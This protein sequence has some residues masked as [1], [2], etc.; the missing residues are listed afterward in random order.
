MQSQSMTTG[1]PSRGFSFF[2]SQ[3]T[4]NGDSP[5]N[6]DLGFGVDTH[7]RYSYQF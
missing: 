2:F 7:S 3:T 1:F 6:A 4:A 5:G